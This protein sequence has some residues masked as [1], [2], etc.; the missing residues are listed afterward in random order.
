MI[1]KNKYL[2]YKEKYL[3][4]KQKIHQD[5]TGGTKQLLENIVNDLYNILTRIYTLFF[6]IHN[7]D[8]TEENIPKIIYEYKQIIEYKINKKCSKYTDTCFF[9]DL[10]ASDIKLHNTISGFLTATK[11]I[12]EAKISDY[13]KEWDNF[14]KSLTNSFTSQNENENM[15]N[16]IPKVLSINNNKM[17]ILCN[18]LNVFRLFY[19]L[20][21]NIFDKHRYTISTIFREPNSYKIQDIVIDKELEKKIKEQCG[22]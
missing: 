4:L 2:K 17:K 9:L 21:N 19:E 16:Y 15:N 3:E 10:T 7:F 8:K 18:I 14:K 11:I 13:L 12:P 22:V 6:L 20:Y 1:Y 5:Q